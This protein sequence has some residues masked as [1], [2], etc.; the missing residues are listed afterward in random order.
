[1]M[2]LMITENGVTFKDL[3]KN[4]YAWVCQIGRQFTQE[5]LE[6]YD[7]LLMEG[8]DRKKYR[9]KGVRQTTVKTVYGEVTYRRTVYETAEEEGT[10]RFVY[11]LDE[12]LELANV[13]LISS[14]M[15]EL[16]VKGITELSYR[17]CAAKVSEM[18]GQTI[19]TMGVWN[20]IQA[21]GEQ[22][23]EEEK[24]LAEEYKKGHIKGEKK[25]PVLFEEADGVYIRLQGKDRKRM[26]QDKAELKVGI[27]Y[28]GWRKTGLDRYTLEDKVAVAG[29]SKAKEFHEYR[30]A[31]IAQTFDLDFVEQRILNAD[32][33]AWIKMVK[34]KSTC[35]QLD[36]FHRNKAVREKIHHPAAQR[37]ILELLEEE[38]IEEVFKYLECYRNSL[39]EEKEIE[40][41]EE[42]IRYYENNRE[43]LLPY[44][45][46][47]LELPESPEGVEYRNMGTMENHIWSII[48]K[49]MKHG[50][51]SFSIR[52]GNHL[53]KILAKKCSGKL[54]EVTERLKKPILEQ[55]KTELICEEILTAAKAPRK[56]GKGYEYPA[57]GH[58]VGLEGKIQGDR[59]WLLH[60]A[61]Y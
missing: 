33:A 15:A 35:F 14:N 34:N 25:S 28:S 37:A 53:A 10:R 42:L 2:N 45:S 48:A 39:W 51:R 7:R 58:V 55:E 36:P 56:D 9:N 32:G 11:L 38:K 43:G 60:L 52:G 54:Y 13:G 5:F 31:Q 49:R 50:H 30:E 19:S 57:I 59:K 18:T 17:E 41:T 3:E 46:Q 24:E 6:R 23:C 1:M 27:A 40:E 16:L 4:I 8:R 20:V 22:V 47:G 12:T 61:G 29:F 26:G 44:Q 21:L